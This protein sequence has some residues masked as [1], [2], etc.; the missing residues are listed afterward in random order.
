MASPAAI[1]GGVANVQDIYPLAPLQEGILF[2]HLVNDTGDAYLITN[3]STFDT[4]EE[5]DAFNNPPSGSHTPA[6]HPAHFHPLGKPPRTRAGRLAQRALNVEEV[7]LDPDVEKAGNAAAQLNE[8]FNPDHYRLNL[9][10]APLLQVRLAF[11]K[12]S[13]PVAVYGVVPPSHRRPH[14]L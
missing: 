14:H 10:L 2:H 8:R 6:R 13:E 5:L 1:P 7:T 4:R 12:T 9:H 3:L 11:D